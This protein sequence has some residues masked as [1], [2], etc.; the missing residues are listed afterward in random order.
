MSAPFPG[1]VAFECILRVTALVV[2]LAPASGLTYKSRTLRRLHG[3]W[4]PAPDA[5]SFDYSW[6]LNWPLNEFLATARCVSILCP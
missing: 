3:G 2:D 6:L 5:A 4:L 1:F